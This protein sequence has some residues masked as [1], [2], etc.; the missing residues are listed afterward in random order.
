MKSKMED[1]RSNRP[2]YSVSSLVVS[3]WTSSL[4][5]LPEI[6]MKDVGDFSN[7]EKPPKSGRVKR[8]Q[9]LRGRIYPRISRFEKLV[10][11]NVK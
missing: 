3:N 10:S 8:I 1:N 4:E 6:V 5:W 7:V 2:V 9:V 11:Q